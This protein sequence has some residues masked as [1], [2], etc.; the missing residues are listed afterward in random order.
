LI[1]HAH[2]VQPTHVTA[3]LVHPVSGR[4]FQIIQARYGVDLIE[5]AL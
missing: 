2:G 1:V 3:E 5:F 4:H